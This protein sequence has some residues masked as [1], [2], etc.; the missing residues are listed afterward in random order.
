MK[1]T[2]KKDR[3]GQTEK[4]NLFANFKIELFWYALLT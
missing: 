4:E 1:I 2:Q 3:V